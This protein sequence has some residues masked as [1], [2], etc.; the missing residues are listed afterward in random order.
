VLKRD[1]EHLYLAAP[2]SSA[3]RRSQTMAS[4]AASVRASSSVQE[5]SDQLNLLVKQL[6]RTAF[7]KTFKPWW[8]FEGEKELPGAAPLLE[9]AHMVLLRLHMIDAALIY[10]K[11]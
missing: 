1:L 9:G 6:P 8:A 2:L 10:G 4:F 7:K 5:L 3:T 11:P